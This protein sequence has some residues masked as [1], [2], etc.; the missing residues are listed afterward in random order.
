[1][2]NKEANPY[3]LPDNLPIP[4]DDGACSHLVG[5]SIPKI[6]LTATNG[7]FVDLAEISKNFAVVYIYPATGIPGQDPIVGWDDIPG[8]PGC[9]LQ[10]LGFSKDLNIF[11]ELG[12]VVFGISSQSQ[13]EQ[14][15]FK[16]RNQFPIEL[17][18]DPELILRDRLNFPT[19][20]AQGKE[21]YR[22]AVLVL[23]RGKISHV[24]YPVFPPDKS[25]SNV[26]AWLKNFRC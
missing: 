21:F 5:L 7:K 14:L 9:T 1:M 20:S 11:K 23:E 12:Y 2:S 13:F 26:I 3:F 16:N 24:F 17:L 19:F 8:A 10:S 18:S 15:E 4:E 25:S 6:I 22:R